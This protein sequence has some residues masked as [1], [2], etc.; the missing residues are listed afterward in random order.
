MADYQAQ[1]AFAET[2]INWREGLRSSTPERASFLLPGHIAATDDTAF[3]PPPLAGARRTASR[4]KARGWRPGGM[5]D[6]TGCRAGAAWTTSSGDPVRGVERRRAEHGR[7][8][9]AVPWTS[10]KDP[11]ARREIGAGGRSMGRG[12]HAHRGMDDPARMLSSRALLDEDVAA[13]GGGGVLLHLRRRVQRQHGA[14]IEDP[15]PL[16]QRAAV[17]LVAADGAA[18]EVCRAAQ[19]VEAAAVGGRPVGLVGVD[20]VVGEREGGVL[21]IDPASLGGPAGPGR[22]PGCC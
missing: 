8:T 17:G 14:V 7:G 21:A 12:R 6:S 1:N 9:R 4:S 15:A 11:V 13:V 2:W 18:L 20:R 3:S 19:Q 10:P 22:W 16:S 5:A